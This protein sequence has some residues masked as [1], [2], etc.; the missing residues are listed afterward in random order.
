VDH[1]V[2]WGQGFGDWGSNDGNGN[3][4]GMNRSTKG[5]IGGVDLPVYQTW[6]VGVLGGFS[7][8]G[9]NVQDRSSAGTS[10]NYHLGVYGGTQAGSVAVRA[11]A[12]Y[13]WNSL[14]TAR[15][16]AFNGFSDQLTAQYNGG[17]IQGFGEVGYKVDA[18]RVSLEPFANLAYVSL[19]TAAF[20]ETGGASALS[21]NGDTSSTTFTTLGLHAKEQL[22]LGIRTIFTARG[23]L[24]WRHAFGDIT[25][26]S[27]NAFAGSSTFNI[28]GVPVAQDAMAVDAGFDAAVSE[29][30][31]LGLSYT[32]QYASSA[33]DNGFKANVGWKF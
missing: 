31:T 8:T 11:G 18:D 33:R 3:A 21:V 13:S 32:G 7:N 1:P 19:H 4:A 16:V 14:Q 23:S 12:A 30:L 15:A 6:R 10:D 28:D 29:H 17:T 27:A 25:P 2:I 5:F 22:D 24:G 26:V 9:L 20:K